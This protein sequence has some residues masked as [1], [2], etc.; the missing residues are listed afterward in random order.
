[1]NNPELTICLV[2][3]NGGSYLP[4]CLNSVFK[5]SFKGWQL[6][7]MDNGSND[8]SA[9]IGAELTGG[10]S[11]AILLPPQEKNIGFAKGYNNLIKKVD[12]KYIILLNQDVILEPD[13]VEKIVDFLDKNPKSGAVIGKILRWNLIES[14]ELTNVSKTSNIDTAG[15][16]IFSSFRIVDVGSGERDS[17]Q[18]NNNEKIFGVS[19]CLP[20][21]RKEALDQAG[22]FDN[23]FFSYKEDVDLAFRLNNFGWESHRVGGAVAYHERSAPD[24]ESSSDIK[25]AFNRKIKSEF[26]RYLSY[27]NHWYVLI[28]NIALTDCMRYG[29]FMFW[30]E[31][32]KFIYIL[33]FEQKT[34][35]A[36][37]D[38]FKNLLVLLKQR[39]KVKLKSVKKF[40]K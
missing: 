21:Y 39:R 12:S 14:G 6:L 26:T 2:T 3:Y 17:G 5:Q 35:L 40:I 10:D 9:K 15:L 30:Y 23:K 24:K 32:K 38:I 22:Y 34:L 29:I 4:H 1:M 16:G 37:V 11:R 31:L 7:I 25:I 36:W 18:F 20:A 19:G 28:K 33:L 8:D 13:Y 27:R